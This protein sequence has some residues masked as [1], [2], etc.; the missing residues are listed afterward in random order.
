MWVQKAKKENKEA[1]LGRL[2]GRGRGGLGEDL[3]SGI[4]PLDEFQR[5]QP[6]KGDSDLPELGPRYV[7]IS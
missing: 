7:V 2:G 5:N 3:G 6:S 4:V 1:G